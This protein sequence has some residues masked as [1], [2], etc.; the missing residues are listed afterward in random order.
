[1]KLIDQIYKAQIVDKSIVEPEIVLITLKYKNQL[2][3][4]R[5]RIHQEDKDFFSPVLGQ[6]IA[7]YKAT[8]KI[9]K[10]EIN[11]YE[12][13]VKE[14]KSFYYEVTHFN[15][16]EDTSLKLRM[17]RNI[18]RLE[19]RIARLKDEYI[20]YRKEYE[21]YLEDIDKAFTSVKKLRAAKA[22]DKIK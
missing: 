21:T 13:I 12:K 7:V 20:M 19:G 11:K 9:F 6:T 14:R 18:K 22:K 15:D 16:E 2:F 8:Q 3:T 17:E 1:M 5:A 4:G 10:Y